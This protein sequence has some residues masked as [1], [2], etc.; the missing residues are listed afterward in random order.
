MVHNQTEDKK[1]LKKMKQ[2]LLLR[3]FSY[4]LIHLSI[5]L[6]FYN[7]LEILKTFSVAKAT[8]ESQLSVILSVTNS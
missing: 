6:E 3:F 1:T 2:N 7:G 8:L 5:D 4:K